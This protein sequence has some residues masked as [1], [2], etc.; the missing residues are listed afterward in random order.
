MKLFKRENGAVS[1]IVIT[2]LLFFAII[3]TGTYMLNATVRKSQIKSQ[4]QLRDEY[5]KLI[6]NTAARN[7]IKTNYTNFLTRKYQALN[8]N[9]DYTG[10]YQTY[11]VKES[12]T[13]K[14]ECWGACGGDNLGIG[15]YTAGNIYLDEGQ[16][17]YFYVGEKG[18]GRNIY[19]AMTQG[20]FNGGGLVTTP[21]GDGH[22]RAGGGATDVR[23]VASANWNTASGINS[24]IMVAGAGGGYVN[25]TE[26]YKNTEQGYG[27]SMPHG[28]TTTSPKVWGHDG[29]WAYGATQT[30]GGDS[31]VTGSAKG[32]N[33]RR[34]S[35]GGGYRGGNINSTGL[36]GTGGSS[37]ISGHSGCTLKSG[38][39]FTST[40]ME[41]GNYT[42]NLNY[43]H[44][45]NV[46]I[47]EVTGDKYTIPPL[48]ANAP[49]PEYS[50]N[51]YARIT[52][53]SK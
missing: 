48:I 37:Y 13:Y 23:L 6:N 3:L 15:A 7:T 39:V 53:V 51:G 29:S 30:S 10:S 14:I 8:A 47:N 40:I 22:N 35:G 12:G 20:A 32:V 42:M 24:R 52:F 43:T 36:A 18:Q 11:I 1:I 4:I 49:N 17:L 5:A 9:F 45:L 25:W 19:Y 26:D 16:I 2:T 33:G 31:S 50:S 44:P 27:G 21:N 38:W 34:A 28:G 46:K 41:A